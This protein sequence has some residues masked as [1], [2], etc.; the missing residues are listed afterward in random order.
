MRVKPQL[1]G[2]SVYITGGT[3]GL[4]RA[5][6]LA[7]AGEGARVGVLARDLDG[8]DDLRQELFQAG[9]P[10]VAVA[11]ADVSDYAQLDAA[12]TA[13]ATELDAPDIWINNAMETVFSRFEDVTPEEFARVTSVTYLGCVHGTRIALQH[14]E[15]QGSGHIIQIGSALAYRAIPLQS[16]YCGA[17]HAIR[18]FTDALRCELIHDCSPIRI[19]AVHM[20]ALNT[21]QFE[22]ARTHID[23]QPQ[24][25]GTIFEPEV[26]A[27]A[28]IYAALHPKREYWVGGS[29]VAAITGNAVAPGLLDHWMAKTTYEGQWIEGEHIAPRDGNLDF[30]EDGMHRTHGRFDERARKRSWLWDLLHPTTRRRDMP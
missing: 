5:I 3:A 1:S 13:L 27:R 29:T 30:P 17:K 7:F 9:A 19:T 28:V 6:A 11:A 22:W 26:G 2:M 21:P 4:G 15:S 12:A 16:A 25:V 23:H 24:P 10:A 8:A 18:G 20:P 14:M